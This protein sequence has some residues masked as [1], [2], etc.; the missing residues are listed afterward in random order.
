MEFLQY[1]VCQ[2]LMGNV[3]GKKVITLKATDHVPNALPPWSGKN[4]TLEELLTRSMK[5]LYIKGLQFCAMFVVTD[6]ISEHNFTSVADICGWNKLLIWTVKSQAM[7]MVKRN[8]FVLT[9]TCLK[10]LAHSYLVALL[11][12]CFIP[13]RNLRS[14]QKSLRTIQ[15]VPQ[16]NTTLFKLPEYIK[17][18]DYVDNIKTCLKT[19]TISRLLMTNWS[20]LSISHTSLFFFWFFSFHHYSTKGQIC[21]VCAI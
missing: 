18:C 4:K 7:L 21:D 12:Q 3:G 11:T 8:N 1:R 14:S 5:N 2:H 19:F 13:N 10:G 17:N 9:F 6:K 15:G 20:R 16:I